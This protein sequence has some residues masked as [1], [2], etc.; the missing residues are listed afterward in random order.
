MTVLVTGAGGQV[1]G[2]LVRRAQ[3]LGIG[4][5]D[6]SRGALDITDGAAIDAVLDHIRP[7]VVVNPAAFTQV[8]AAESDPDAAFAVNA[9]AVASLGRACATR[10]VPLL[11]LSTDYVFPGGVARP[12]TEEDAVAPVNTYGR[13]KAAGEALLREVHG[14]HVIVRTSWVFGARGGNFVHTMLR[15]AR[16]RDEVR[17]VADEVGCPTAADA[18]ADALLTLVQSMV[19]PGFRDWGTYHCC[20]TPAVS[21]AD[22]A[23][24]LFE[25]AERIGGL[26]TARVRDIP[27]DAFP[28]AARRPSYTAMDCGRLRGVF[29]IECEAWHA[30]LDRMLRELARSERT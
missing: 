18:L 28:S 6:L 22:F 17:V 30:G 20:G 4:V 8:D 21:R 5:A 10:G 24:A 1:G 23:R 16:E 7:D 3:S 19:E 14:A 29:G 11:H 9:T 26:P 25:A 27:A 15:L 12:Y 13:S 2:A